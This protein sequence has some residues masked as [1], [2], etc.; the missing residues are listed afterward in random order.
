MRFPLAAF[1]SAAALLTAPLAA[2]DLA[3][4]AAA[5]RQVVTDAYVDGIHNFYDPAAIRKGFH[6]GF[7][8]LVLKDGQLEKLPLEA[9]IARLGEAN[10]KAPRPAPGSGVRSTRAEFPIVEIAGTAAICRVEVFR[11][12]RHVFT[13]FLN[14]YRFEDAWKI[15]GKTFYRYP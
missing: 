2:N 12:G 5:V 3:A 10:A 15:V 9:W 11:D 6:A 8:M 1:L 14:L 7:E 13:D 4:E